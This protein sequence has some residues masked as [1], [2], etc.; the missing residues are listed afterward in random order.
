MNGPVTRAWAQGKQ[1][2]LLPPDAAPAVAAPLLATTITQASPS[3]PPLFWNLCVHRFCHIYH[4]TCF[5]LQ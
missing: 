2:S 3:M 1:W 5:H 4:D